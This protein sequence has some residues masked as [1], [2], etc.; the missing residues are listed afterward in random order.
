ME[1]RKRAEKR[2]IPVDPDLAPPSGSRFGIE[3]ELVVPTNALRPICRFISR[4]VGWSFAKEPTVVPAA[5][6]TGLEIQTP[7]LGNLRDLAQ[8]Q[9]IFDVLWDWGGRTNKTCALHV[10]VSFADLSWSQ[11]P[12]RA[13]EVRNIHTALCENLG[14]IEQDYI[15]PHRI[16]CG[17][18]G[19]P[20]PEEHRE[21]YI[22]AW[23]TRGMFSR[24][25]Y[26]NCWTK[27]GT[28]EWR[29]READD[30]PHALGYVQQIVDF[31]ARARANP[32]ARLPAYS[33]LS[34]R[35]LPARFP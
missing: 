27:Y 24:F 15:A 19:R 34:G 33:Q 16:N 35:G 6:E 31:T 2:H 17:Y 10:H 7:V 5:G 25:R 8:V 28:V 22:E 11:V 4:E 32:N 12:R 14:V 30:Y 9:S 3:L 29:M 21:G 20:M 26:L 1:K 23:V 13:S 18:A